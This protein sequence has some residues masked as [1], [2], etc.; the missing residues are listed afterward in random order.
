MDVDECGESE[1]GQFE[2]GIVASHIE[3]RV[4]AGWECDVGGDDGCDDNEQL[5]RDECCEHRD[6]FGDGSWRR[7][8]W[9]AVEHV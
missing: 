5:G 2:C 3:Q 7:R 9:R 1:S 4:D 8:L 6:C